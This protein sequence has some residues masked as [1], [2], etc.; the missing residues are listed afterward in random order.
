MKLL[1]KRFKQ[2]GKVSISRI[3]KCISAYNGL[4]TTEA[5]WMS[6]PPGGRI[7]ISIDESAT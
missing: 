7:E 6:I 2:N 1:I 4:D 3:E 5:A